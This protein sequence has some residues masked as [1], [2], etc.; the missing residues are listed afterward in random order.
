MGQILRDRLKQSHFKSAFQ[1]ATLNVLVT[2]DYLKEKIDKLCSENGITAQQY[3]VLRILKGAYPNGHPRREI[4][5]RM[6]ERSPDATRLID[7]LEERELVERTISE[8]DKRLS[9]TKITLKGLDIV[10]KMALPIEQL[11]HHLFSQFSPEEA[12][13]LSTLCE[14][15]YGLSNNKSF[16]K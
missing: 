2:A 15:I 8:T 7:R 5:C 13:M 6:I 3:N 1:E 14:K 12:E 16:D 11:D 10:N 4:L 9:I